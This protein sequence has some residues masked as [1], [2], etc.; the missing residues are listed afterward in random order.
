MVLTIGLAGINIQ[1]FLSSYNYIKR[2]ISEFNDLMEDEGSQSSL[3]VVSLIIYFVIPVIYLIM[4]TKANFFFIGILLLL[5]KF[6]ISAIL[7]FWTQNRILSQQGYTKTVHLLGKFDN[8]L[9]I[10]TSMA[11]IYLLLFPI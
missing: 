10:V 5:S 11:V 1:Q 4:L 6:I 3:N 7:G 9:N 2:K 8:L